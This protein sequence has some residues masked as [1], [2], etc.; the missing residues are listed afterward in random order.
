VPSVDIITGISFSLVEVG[1]V[2]L[3]V[4]LFD[5]IVRVKIFGSRCTTICYIFGQIL[6]YSHW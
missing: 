3:E 5:M 1:V 4:L 6:V 2:D